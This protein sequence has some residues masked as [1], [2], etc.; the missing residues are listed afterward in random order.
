MRKPARTPAGDAKFFD[1]L[2]AGLAVGAA[3]AASGYS[4]TAVYAWCKRYPGFAAAWR[5]ADVVALA[6]LE[7]EANN[8]LI[9]PSQ[10]GEQ[11]A[12]Q[13]A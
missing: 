11:R 7:A 10:S 12:P 4:R 5:N 6:A 13:R 2:E 3:L 9:R 1:V 8:R